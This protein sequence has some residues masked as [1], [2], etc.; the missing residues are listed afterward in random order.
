MARGTGAKANGQNDRATGEVEINPET[1]VAAVVGYAAVDDVGNI[2]ISAA[3]HP[4]SCA[5]CRI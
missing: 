1:G 2:V 4:S 5:D 3:S